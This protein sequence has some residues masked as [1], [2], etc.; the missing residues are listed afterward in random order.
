MVQ[1]ISAGFPC[2]PVAGRSVL[3]ELR[4][5]RIRH[6]VEVVIIGVILPHVIDAEEIVAT[7]PAPC[8]GSLMRA[9]KL[10]SAPVTG[11]HVGLFGSGATS[12]LDPDGIEVF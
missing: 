8:L 11:A 5:L 1:G 4:N 7:V 2:W 3:L 10:T 6:P 12:G 9:G